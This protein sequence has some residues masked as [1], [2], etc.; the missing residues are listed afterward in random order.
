MFDG[1][2]VDAAGYI[3]FPSLGQIKVIGMTIAEL[4]K[5]LAKD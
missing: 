4:R 3:N 5:I 2:Q 1:Y